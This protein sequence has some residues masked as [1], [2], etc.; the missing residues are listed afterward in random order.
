[1]FSS[2]W[3][4]T[5]TTTTTIATSRSP[6]N[7]RNKKTQSRSMT[8]TKDAGT[9]PGINTNSQP[10]KKD[11]ATGGDMSQKTTGTGYTNPSD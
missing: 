3:I 8:P 1:M 2:T 6:P 10:V 7:L 4:T 9:G 5:T 11:A